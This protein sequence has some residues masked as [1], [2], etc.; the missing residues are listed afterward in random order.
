[1]QNLLVK[2]YQAITE[3]Q[4]KTIDLFCQLN[5][6]GMLLYRANVYLDEKLIG[7]TH[8]QR[9][10]H[11]AHNN[12]KAYTCLARALRHLT[13]HEA[14]PGYKDH[15]YCSK[16]ARKQKSIYHDLNLDCNHQYPINNLAQNIN[17]EAMLELA[18]AYLDAG[19]YDTDTRSNSKN[20]IYKALKSSATFRILKKFKLS[21]LHSLAKH[22]YPQAEL[23]LVRKADIKKNKFE[24]RDQMRDILERLQQLPKGSPNKEV[25]IARCKSIIAEC[26]QVSQPKQQPQACEFHMTL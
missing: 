6:P 17:T 9:A 13:R 10:I 24:I 1:M 20:I 12:L 3:L 23:A 2:K 21:M 14:F 19:F 25:S 7:S 26:S 22:D 11:N 15:N 4:E 18:Q 16:I 8:T 5:H